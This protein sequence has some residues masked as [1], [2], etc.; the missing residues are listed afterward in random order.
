LAMKVAMS[1]RLSR[2]LKFKQFVASHSADSVTEAVNAA[3]DA[4]G[5]APDAFAD[6]AARRALQQSDW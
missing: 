4:A 1:D 3:V 2:Y 5:G 6:R